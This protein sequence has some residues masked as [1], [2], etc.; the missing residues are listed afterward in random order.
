ME[1]FENCDVE[2]CD[3]ALVTLRDHFQDQKRYIETLYEDEDDEPPTQLVALPRD[4]AAT[5]E[6]LDMLQL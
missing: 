6:L 3:D 4:D 2:F 5:T 1:P